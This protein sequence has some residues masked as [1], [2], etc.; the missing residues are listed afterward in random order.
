M[1]RMALLSAVCRGSVVL[2]AALIPPAIC[3]AQKRPIAHED[4]WLAGRLSAPVVSP[5]GRW[6]AVQV[7]EPAYDERDQSSDLWLIA[8]DAKTAPRRLTGTKGAESGAAW[9]PDGRRIAFS[10]RRDG[11][12]AAQI[13]VIDVN[14]G[15][16]HRVTNLFTGAR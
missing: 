14:G 13:Y 12:E 11:D 16:A 8:V 2:I 1:S 5:D 10:A 9:S 15:E 6:A 3:A 7:T 4:V